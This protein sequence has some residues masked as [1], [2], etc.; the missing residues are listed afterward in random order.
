L[1]IILLG[2]SGLIGNAFS[3]ELLAH[4]HSVWILTR[5]PQQIV[6]PTGA[7]VRGWDGCTA[8]GWMDLVEE[9]DVLVNLAGENIGSSRWTAQRKMRILSSRQNAGQAVVEAVRSARHKPGLVIQSSAVGYYGASGNAG[10]A[11]DAPPGSDFLA[12][13]AQ[14]W[15]D[16]SRAVEMEAVRRI[17]LRTG[18]VLDPQEGILARFRLPFQIFAGG[19]MGSGKQVISWIHIHDQVQAMRF[20]L[21]QPTTSGVYNLCAP[22]AVTNAEFGKEIARALHRPYWLPVPGFALRILLGEMSTLVVDGQRVE[23]LR[24]LREGYQFT[25]PVLRPALEKLLQGIA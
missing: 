1:N 15:E 22:G 16:S 17:V 11:E 7:Q 4:G 12:R 3:R 13:V 8:T 14:Q 6:I 2:G 10:M 18:V 19:P 25:Y 9:A 21:E 24:L 20:L 5:R 23:P